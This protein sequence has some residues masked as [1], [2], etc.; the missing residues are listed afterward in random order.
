MRRRRDLVQE[1]G[2]SRRV[3]DATL[4]QRALRRVIVEGISL[5]SAAYKRHEE[6]ICRVKPDAE[7]RIRLREQLVDAA[8][9]TPRYQELLDVAEA[10][11]PGVS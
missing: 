2:T 1:E 9:L 8:G 7:E 10:G 11:P 4:R 6:H 5:D 3:D